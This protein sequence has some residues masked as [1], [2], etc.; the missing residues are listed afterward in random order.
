[1]AKTS[2]E[3]HDQELEGMKPTHRGKLIG[4]NTIFATADTPETWAGYQ[5]MATKFGVRRRS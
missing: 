4:I 1:M 2:K 3:R 5:T